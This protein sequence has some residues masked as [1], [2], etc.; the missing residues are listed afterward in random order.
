MGT[1]DVTVRCDGWTDVPTLL[2]VAGLSDF[3]SGAYPLERMVLDLRGAH[4]PAKS[5]ALMEMPWAGF[6]VDEGRG[7]A[8]GRPWLSIQES[9][10]SVRQGDVVELLPNLDKAVIRYR[11]G[12]NGNVLFATE[13]CNSY[14]L[15][16]SQPPRQVEDDWRVDQLCSLVDLID[17]DERQVAVSGGEPTLLGLGLRR[18]IERCADVIPDTEV[19]VLSNGRLLAER[20]YAQAFS[21]VHEKLSW[22]IPL[23]G[24]SYRLHDYIVQ[25]PGAFAQTLRGLY[26]LNAAH[27]PIEIRVVLVKPV[28]ERLAQIARYIYRNFSFVEHVAFMGIEPTGFARAN[29]ESLWIDPVDI[30]APLVDAV[31]FLSRRAIRTS[32]YNLPLCTLPEAV[33]PYSQRSIS[34]W[35]QRYLPECETCSVQEQCGGVFAWITP[36]WTSRAIASINGGGLPCA[37]H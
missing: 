3:A 36:Q 8:K 6:L 27:Q 33:W 19:H 28:V 11:R 30:A 21:G 12:G 10:S 7:G 17:K 35:K 18:I 22:G 14:C 29:H 32:I 20:A 1:H 25:S 24:D 5:A 23:Y 16:C 15:M 31:D 4:T 9:K 37:R 26:S 2:K 13:R 34:D